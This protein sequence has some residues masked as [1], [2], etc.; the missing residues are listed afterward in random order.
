MVAFNA[1]LTT[2]TFLLLMGSGTVTMFN[3]GDRF[4]RATGITARVVTA[5]SVMLF[6]LMFDGAF[7]FQQ[8]SLIVHALGR[9]A[10]LGGCVASLLGAVAAYVLKLPLMRRIEAMALFTGSV[11]VTI[12]VYQSL[13]G[14]AAVAGTVSF[15]IGATISSGVAAGAIALAVIR[16]WPVAAS[17]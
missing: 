11:T 3:E 10:T 17:V 9:F 5:V 4:D 15:F 12:G 8:N 7:F 1:A 2:A 13:D 6:V 16:R 14:W